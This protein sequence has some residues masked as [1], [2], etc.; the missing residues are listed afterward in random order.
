[1]KNKFL[2]T[3]GIL[4]FSITLVSEY[5]NDIKIKSGTIEFIKESNK[6]NFLNDVVID[7]EFVNIV[8]ESAIYDD[9]NS[10]ISLLGSPSLISSNKQDNLF[11]GKAE[12]ILFFNDEKVHLIG[13]ASMKY[14]NISISSNIIIFNPQ[15]GNISS[16]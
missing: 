14:E 2:V 5:S 7:S 8:A 16:D 6:I 10:V 11:D 12:K 13:N 4:F 9:I 15:T 3:F 1:L